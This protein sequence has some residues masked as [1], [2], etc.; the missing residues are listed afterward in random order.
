MLT[1]NIRLAFLVFHSDI[2]NTKNH[3]ETEIHIKTHK[4]SNKEEENQPDF[5][6]LKGEGRG[7]EN[8]KKRKKKE[9]YLTREVAD[10]IS[11]GIFSIELKDTSNDFSIGSL[12]NVSK[13]KNNKKCIT[14]VKNSK[15]WENILEKYDK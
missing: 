6:K 12:S 5:I 2:S 3:K 11:S 4:N 7:K 10:P 15:K 8:K 13:R 14:L 9:R 1:N